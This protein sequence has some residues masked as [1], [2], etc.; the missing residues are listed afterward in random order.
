MSND[1]LLTK[2]T[3]ALREE[4]RGDDASAHFTRSRIMASALEERVRRRTH[5]AFL[6]PIAATFLAASAWGAA[7]GKLG[8]AVSALTEAIG[9]GP[10][11]PAPK[12]P[13]TLQPRR[14]VPVASKPEPALEPPPPAPPPPAPEPPPEPAA[15]QSTDAPAPASSAMKPS[16]GAGGSTSDP[17]FELYRAAHHAHFV[18]RDSARA[19]V[20]W[21]AYLKAAPKAALSL[22]ARY[23]RALCLVRLRRNAEA[24]VAL[25][26]FAE[27]RYDGYRKAEA[28]ELIRALPSELAEPSESGL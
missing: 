18:E 23:N 11:A 20:A 21:D 24:R 6:I 12:A 7:N 17:A 19:L 8:R 28:S 3:R 2:A 26:P 14:N 13:E 16:N 9:L 5:L 10:A 4:T 27:G 15:R 22:E 1:D 25:L